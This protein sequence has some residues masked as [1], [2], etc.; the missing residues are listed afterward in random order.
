V[1]PS[2]VSPVVSQASEFTTKPA[3]DVG[4][5]VVGV[6]EFVGVVFEPFLKQSFSNGLSN[7]AGEFKCADIQMVLE[8]S[9]TS[10]LTKENGT[11]YQSIGRVD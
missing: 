7:R 6:S 4:Q 9:S 8:G 5:D 2:V 1:S 11:L 10:F 3:L